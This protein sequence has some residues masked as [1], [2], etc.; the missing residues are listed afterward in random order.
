M[1]CLYIDCA[2]GDWSHFIPFSQLTE[3][4]SVLVFAFFPP[5]QNRKPSLLSQSSPDVTSILVD[6]IDAM[7][8][9]LRA[10]A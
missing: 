4:T 1:A 7:A 8:G 10:P 5:A 9:G 3:T 6:L 2:V